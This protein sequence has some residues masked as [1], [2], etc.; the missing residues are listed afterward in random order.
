MSLADL[1]AFLLAFSLP[2]LVT[3]FLTPQVRR[4]ALAFGFTDRPSPRREPTLKPRLGG[5]AIYCGFLVGVLATFPLLGGRSAEEMRK[6]LGL[7][8]GA[9]VV[10][11]MGV[12][13]DRREL[14]PTSQ[15]ALQLLAASLALASGVK[16]DR[17]TNPLGTPLSDSMFELPEYLALLATLFW[18]L[19]AMNTINFLDGLDGL[20]AGVT[21]IAALALFL[22]S[23]WLGQYSIALLPMSLAGAAL[24]FLP[25][26]FYPAKITMGT[27]GAVFLGYALGNISIIGG[28]KAA[29]VLLVLGLPLLDAA[30]IILSRLR[31]GGSPFHADRSHLHHRLMS[32]GLSHPQI[33]LLFYGLCALFGSLALLLSSRILKLYALVGMVLLLSG[34][35]ALITQ[36]SL[37]RRG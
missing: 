17:I 30:W 21:L 3:L 33:V 12:L 27:S 1:L 11:G 22:H 19:G 25:H 34:F 13:D 37:E 35:L 14:S 4:L 15:F 10:V 2:L 20:A 32:L 36:R 31:R 28:T 7:I 23:F 9:A 29:T 16:I 8:A 6:L 18:L 5:L 24:G 26:N